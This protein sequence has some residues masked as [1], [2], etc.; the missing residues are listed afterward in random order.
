MNDGIFYVAVEGRPREIFQVCLKGIEFP[1]F[2]GCPQ[3]HL[4][5]SERTRAF[6]TRALGDET[7]MLDGL[8]PLPGREG[9]CMGGRFVRLLNGT[10]INAEVIKQGLGR[11]CRKCEGPAFDELRALEQ[12]AHEAGL[13]IWGLEGLP[14]VTVNDQAS[15]QAESCAF[16]ELGRMACAVEGSFPPP[17]IIK[18]VDPH[19]PYAALKSGVRG[20]TGL[21]YAHAVVQ[22]DGSLGDIAILKSPGAQYGFDEM[23]LRALRKWKYEPVTFDGRLVEVPLAIAVDFQLR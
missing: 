14:T 13:G 12:Q 5:I 21:L 11:V 8:P 22:K 17:K 18:K 7:V 10:L 19:Y 6:L 15:R 2:S 23:A 1:D 20:I 16:R 3:S 4:A 9:L